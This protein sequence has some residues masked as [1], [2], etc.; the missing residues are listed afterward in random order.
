MRR[1]REITLAMVSLLGSLPAHANIVIA[2]GG[3]KPAINDHVEWDVTITGAH[4]DWGEEPRFKAQEL[5][6]F[7][8]LTRPGTEIR[9]NKIAKSYV[10]Y[11]PKGPKARA[12]QWSRKVPGEGCEIPKIGSQ[13]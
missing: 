10:I 6:G 8:V 5:G 12:I 7:Y 4:A 11:G 2:C 3:Y 1:R 9:I 13:P